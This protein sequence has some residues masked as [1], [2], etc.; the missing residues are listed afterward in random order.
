MSSFVPSVLAC[1]RRSGAL[2]EAVRLDS[3]ALAALTDAVVREDWPL[4]LKLVAEH[5]QLYEN[6]S[7]AEQLRLDDAVVAA[8]A[9]AAIVSRK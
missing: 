6:Y 5:W 4:V 2:S 1:C 8:S 9:A 7:A 3:A